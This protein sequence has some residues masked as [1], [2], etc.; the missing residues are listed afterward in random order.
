MSVCYS[1][2]KPGRGAY[3]QGKL[4][5][6]VHILMGE[7]DAQLQCRLILA[8]ASDVLRGPAARRS[9]DRLENVCFGERHRTLVAAEAEGGEGQATRSQSRYREE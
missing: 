5:E 6:L 1:V 2:G 8:E 7:L 9:L 3:V 4:V